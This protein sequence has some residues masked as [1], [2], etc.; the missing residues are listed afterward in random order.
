MLLNVSDR[1]ILLNVLSNMGGNLVTL[2]IVRDLQREVGF[3]EEESSVLAFKQDD[4]KLFWND[5]VVGEREFAV[6][7]TAVGLVL[8]AFKKL[9]EKEELT[10]QHLPLYEKCLVSV[11]EAKVK[12]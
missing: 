1:L 3:S 2:R 4:Q 12:Q 10:M 7:P 9:E 8:V 5:T 11:E 6:G